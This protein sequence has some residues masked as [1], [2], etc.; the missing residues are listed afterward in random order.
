MHFGGNSLKNPFGRHVRILG[1][2]NRFPSEQ[3]YSMTDPMSTLRARIVEL[4]GR[5]GLPQERGRCWQTKFRFKLQLVSDQSQPLVPSNREQLSLFP[6]KFQKEMVT[7]LPLIHFQ[8][9][10]LLGSLRAPNQYCPFGSFLCLLYSSQL[11]KPWS[12]GEVSSTRLP[13]LTSQNLRALSKF[14]GWLL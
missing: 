3:R 10:G 13:P 6:G 11:R 7:S 4:G 1:P 12:A 8:F 5:S 9:C 2:I 14:K